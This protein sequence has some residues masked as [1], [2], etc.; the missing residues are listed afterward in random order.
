[1]N[2]LALCAGYG[3]LELGISAALGPAYRTIGYVEREAYVAE[4]LIARMQEGRIDEAPIW[5]D[6]PRTLA[7]ADQE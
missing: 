7:T 4:L 5:D 2:G 6:L 1:M 3:G